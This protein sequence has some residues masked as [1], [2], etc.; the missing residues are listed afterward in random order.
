MD[1]QL[2]LGFTCIFE[3]MALLVLI[4]NIMSFGSEYN[5]DDWNAKYKITNIK[6]TIKWI[7]IVM[8]V[9]PTYPILIPAFFLFIIGGGVF[10]AIGN[11]YFGILHLFKSC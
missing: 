1:F 7:I 11:F 10:F 4:G 9:I 3:V 8:L 5:P 2:Y 6:E